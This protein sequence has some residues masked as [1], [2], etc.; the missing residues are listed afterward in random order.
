MI[1]I[2]GDGLDAGVFEVQKWLNKTY[3]GVSDY[4]PIV[5]DGETGSATMYALTRALQH[6]LGLTTLADN[7]G[8]ATLAALTARG[9]VKVDDPVA[10]M[11]TIVQAACYCKGYDPGGLTG[12]F[13]DQTRAAV[14]ALMSDAGISGTLGDAVPPKVVKALLTM[15]AYVLLPGGREAVRAM[16]RWLNG[17][18][19]G[20]ANFF[21]LP[22]D[23]VLSPRDMQRA[24]AYAMQYEIGL[25]DAVA[26]G[27]FGPA[28]QGGVRAHPLAEGATGVWVSLFSGALILTGMGTAFTDAY[29]PELTAEVRAFQQFSALPDNGTADF[30]TWCQTMVST[31]DP[32]RPGTACDGITTITAERAA[33][34]TT[35]GVQFV[36]RYLDE[37]PT[38]HPLNKRIQPGELDVIFGAGLRVFPISQYW[39][40]DAGYFTYQQG[41]DDASDADTAAAGYGFAPGTV[42]YFAVDYDAT[43]AQIEANIIPYFDGVVAGLAAKGKRYVH[44]VYGARNVCSQVSARTSA[45]WSFVAGMS[46]GYSGNA[47]F[48]LPGNWAFNQVKTLTIGTGAG[49]IEIDKDI[50]RPG[51]DPGT[52]AVNIPVASGAEFVAHVGQIRDLAAAYGQGDPDSLVW[53][54]LRHSDWADPFWSAALGARNTDFVAYVSQAGITPVLLFTDPATGVA[55]HAA[56]LAAAVTGARAAVRASPRRVALGDI[57]GWG[58]NLLTFYGE[59]QR[60]SLTV[61][62]GR[63]YCQQRLATSADVGTFTSSDLF[64]AADG[65]NLATALRA[66]TDATRAVEDLYVRNGHQTR[67]RRFV[68][69]RFGCLRDVETA[70][71]D[72]LVDN[73]DPTLAALR[74]RLVRSTGGPGAALPA[75]LPR[76]SLKDFCRGFADTLAAKAQ[77]ETPSRM[78]AA[79]W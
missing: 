46:T 65:F 70:A 71:A 33:T 52:S 41:F 44:G 45:R 4:N 7:F 75:A 73:T 24:L 36:G 47:G 22:C 26:N 35:A 31:G 57:G 9:G 78:R 25:T 51:S 28:T 18:Y 20:R 30:A 12:V 23:G 49:A 68:N 56:R 1:E 62:S 37:R 77:Q 66:G 42:I 6:E 58:A 40:G 76:N 19:L 8:A 55:L 53:D 29:G 74:Q 14:N 15:D 48:P 43:G 59:W 32:D 61:S 64:V 39:G 5:V 16:Q 11:I 72:L 67:L 10:N 3:A 34:L 50:Y 79:S 69:G 60:D 63:T 54:Y 13:S 27:N 2:A 21:V 17:R 38:S